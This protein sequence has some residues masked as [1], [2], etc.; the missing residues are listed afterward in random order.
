MRYLTCALPRLPQSLPTAGW[1]PNE[2]EM[3]LSRAHML[4]ITF[5][6]SQAH[7]Q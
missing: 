3:V 4:R 6:H 5:Q 7:L 2:L 1:G